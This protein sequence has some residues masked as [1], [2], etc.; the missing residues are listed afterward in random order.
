MTGKPLRH[1]ERHTNILDFFRQNWRSK[2]YHLQRMEDDYSE[3][4]A[5][6]NARENS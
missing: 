3:I 5:K 6:L 4:D 1:S 2:W